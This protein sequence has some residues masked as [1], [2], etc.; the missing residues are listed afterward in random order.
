MSNIWEIAAKSGIVKKEEEDDSWANVINLNKPDVNYLRT[1]QDAVEC[2]ITMLGSVKQAVDYF[3][4]L[5]LMENDMVL[6][7]FS[8]SFQVASELHPKLETYVGNDLNLFKLNSKVFQTMR[9]PPEGYE[10]MRRTVFSTA[11]DDLL[12]AIQN[13][14]PSVFDT[15]FSLIQYA[16]EVHKRFTDM[17]DVNAHSLMYSEKNELVGWNRCVNNNKWI[18]GKRWA[19][20]LY[21]MGTMIPFGHYNI[22]TW[23]K[24]L[25]EIVA[26]ARVNMFDINYETLI[27]EIDLLFMLVFGSVMNNQVRRVSPAFEI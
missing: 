17:G 13:T 5:C 4:E 6:H 24:F 12:N 22:P 20:T 14:K 15:T 9:S 25:Q 21:A 26:Y 2:L 23:N 11:V 1:K 8:K 18:Y 10:F 16:K 7:L 19:Y 3:N 27:R